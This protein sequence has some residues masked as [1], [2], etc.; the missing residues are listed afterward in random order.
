ME[1]PNLIRNG[2]MAFQQDILSQLKHSRKW[3]KPMRQLAW[4]VGGVTMQ[5]VPQQPVVICYVFAH[6]Q[7]LCVYSRQI[8]T[9]LYSQPPWHTLLESR[10]SQLCRCQDCRGWRRQGCEDDREGGRLPGPDIA[11]TVSSL[12]QGKREGTGRAAGRLPGGP[13]GLLLSSGPQAASRSVNTSSET[14]SVAVDV[15]II[16]TVI[17]I[18]N[19]GR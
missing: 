17:S 5:Q 4:V 7:D 16:C 19:P 12:Q 14:N 15:S 11:G 10:A 18:Q 3:P 8:V 13:C 6:P 1:R 9:R 2:L